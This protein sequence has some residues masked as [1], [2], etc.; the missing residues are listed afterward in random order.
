MS[1]RSWARACSRRINTN[2]TKGNANDFDLPCIDCVVYRYRLG[3]CFVAL[4]RACS[5]RS[6]GD[7]Q[8]VAIRNPEAIAIVQT[9]PTSQLFPQLPALQQLVHAGRRFR[10]LRRLRIRR[11]NGRRTERITRMSETNP[12]RDGP[13]RFIPWAKRPRGA[14]GATRGCHRSDQ[15]AP[16]ERPPPEGIYLTGRES[17]V[18][19]PSTPKTREPFSIQPTTKTKKRKETRR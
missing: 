2:K 7:S 9:V 13:G 16:Q 15:G 10:I 1:A 4:C 17:G 19:R 12:R 8:D 11:Q 6:E 18:G 5:P 14:T 3:N